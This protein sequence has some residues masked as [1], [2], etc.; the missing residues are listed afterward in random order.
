MLDATQ[1]TFL[2]V[3]TTRFAIRDDKLQ[4]VI[5]IVLLHCQTALECVCVFVLP[6]IPKNWDHDMSITIIIFYFDQQFLTERHVLKNTSQ[7][8]S[9]R[10]DSAH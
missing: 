1:Q 6:H 3:A 2:E 5:V 9:A 8:I 4:L 10:Q 7:N